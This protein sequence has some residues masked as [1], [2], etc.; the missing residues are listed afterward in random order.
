MELRWW[1][2]SSSQWADKRG[3]CRDACHVARCT[4]QGQH[5]EVGMGERQEGEGEREQQEGE[6]EGEEGEQQVGRI[7][8]VICMWVEGRRDRGA[9][10]RVGR[11]ADKG[12]M[13]TSEKVLRRC[14]SAM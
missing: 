5:W 11:E 7:V 14:P 13:H 2:S 6:G 4:A 1:H 12:T 10:G 8:I 3:P 9:G